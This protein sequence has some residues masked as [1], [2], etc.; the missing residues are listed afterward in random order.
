MVEYNEGLPEENITGE[1][2]KH[3]LENLTRFVEMDETMIKDFDDLKSQMTQVGKDLRAVI[4]SSGKI[5]EVKEDEKVERSYVIRRPIYDGEIFASFDERIAYISKHNTDGKDT[6][7]IF[8][9]TIPITKGL[10]TDTIG[11]DFRAID[12]R[13]NRQF[14]LAQDPTNRDAWYGYREIAREGVKAILDDAIPPTQPPK[15]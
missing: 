7:S 14:L 10:H 11:V 12:W 9:V 6:I 3:A 8:S 5:Q 15:I 2:Y 4:I 1:A 13:T